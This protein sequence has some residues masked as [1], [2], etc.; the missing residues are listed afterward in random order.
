[1]PDE[2]IKAYATL[3][4]QKEP[5][6]METSINKMNDGWREKVTSVPGQKRKEHTI[7]RDTQ[8]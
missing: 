5:E 7:S 2:L 4:G 3:Y 8:P 6:A 1:M